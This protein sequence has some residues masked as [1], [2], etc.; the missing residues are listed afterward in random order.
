MIWNSASDFWHMGGYGLY[1]W[2]SMGVTAAGLV[3][4]V[5]LSRR[6]RQEAIQQVKDALQAQGNTEDWVKD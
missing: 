4:E 2:G 6:G 1:V 3:I 5:W